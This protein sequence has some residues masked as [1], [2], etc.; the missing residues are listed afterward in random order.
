MREPTHNKELQE[1][2][3]PTKMYVRERE[4]EEGASY[5]LP[6]NK[7]FSTSNG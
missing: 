7:Q 6:Y 5:F 3:P 2:A 4:E 1:K